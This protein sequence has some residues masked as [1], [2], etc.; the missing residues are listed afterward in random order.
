M[1]FFRRH[2]KDRDLDAEIQ[3][4]LSI[5]IDERVERGESRDEATANARRE[6]GNVALVQ[7]VTRSMWRWSR[8]E[9]FLDGVRHAVRYNLASFVREPVSGIVITLT[10]GLILAGVMTRAMALTSCAQRDSSRNNCFLPSGV[11]R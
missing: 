1:M 9:R 5:A 4:H 7:E 8:V 3:A 2:R 6:F 10:L 11:S